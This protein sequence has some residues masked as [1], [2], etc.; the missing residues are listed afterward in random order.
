MKKH[1]K[2]GPYLN[3]NFVAT[4][5]L[6]PDGITMKRKITSFTVG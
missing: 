5:L 4:S 2:K 6:A 1:Y 3:L